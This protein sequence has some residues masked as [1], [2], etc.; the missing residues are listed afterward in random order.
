MN[1][2]KQWRTQQKRQY[3]R[4]GFNTMDRKQLIFA[5]RKNKF[6]SLNTPA[7]WQNKIIKDFHLKKITVHGWRH[8]S[9]S[10]LF[11]IN[12]PIKEVQ[13]RLGHSDVQTTLNIYA[14]VTKEQD[15]ETA[16][17]LGKAFNF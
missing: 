9:C 5:N 13:K 16:N 3:M 4:L 2:L 14:H 12:T 7:K 8:T 1:Y 11:A 17:R 10:L 15:S 6:K